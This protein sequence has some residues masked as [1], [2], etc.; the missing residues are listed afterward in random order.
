MA[1]KT[2]V[3]VHKGHNCSLWEMVKITEEDGTHKEFL[4]CKSSGDVLQVTLTKDCDVFA[5]KVHWEA[6]KA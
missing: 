3:L 4:R 5:N 6:E 2:E 1:N